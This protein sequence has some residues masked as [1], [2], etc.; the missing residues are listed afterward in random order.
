MQSDCSAEITNGTS[1]I[2]ER[3]NE[4]EW[5]C[6]NYERIVTKSC[7][8]MTMQ[9]CA[10]SVGQAAAW[11]TGPEQEPVGADNWRAVQ[12]FHLHEREHHQAH[13]QE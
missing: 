9:N 11:T 10:K 4:E 2:A 12:R 6:N 3:K 13:W 7:C 5:E 8:E 1:K